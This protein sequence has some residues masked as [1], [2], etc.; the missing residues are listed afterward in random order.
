MYFFSNVPARVLRFGMIK[1]PAK[2]LSHGSFLPTTREEMHA[3]SIDMLDIIIVTGD[4]YIDHPAFGAA[5]VGRF[6]QSLGLTV[7]II[8]MPDVNAPADFTWLGSA[9]LFFRRY[10]R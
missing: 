10:G 4:A 5:I 6:L 8:A 9:A 2:A 7:G 3:L 1:H